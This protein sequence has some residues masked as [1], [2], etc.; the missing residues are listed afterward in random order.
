LTVLF[1]WA[2]AL[3][4]LFRVFKKNGQRPSSQ[5]GLAA[6]R[7][8][9]V[10]HQICRRGIRDPRVLEAMRK[11]ERHRFVSDAQELVAYGDHP[12][13]IGEGQTIS[14][15]YIVALMSEALGLEGSETVLEVGTGSGYQTAI[16][17]ELA[18]EVFSVEI[19]PGLAERA[20]SVLDAMGYR[21]VHIR[22][23]DGSRGWP[24]HAAY[25]GILVTAAPPGVPAALLEQLGDGG[26]LVIPVGVE[27]QELE[28]HTRQNEGF[29]VRRLAAV[30]FVPLLDGR[31]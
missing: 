4:G 6:E 9:M 21:N 14:Q 16:L 20:R 19:V 28:V 17:A 1:G 5:E 30:R 23:G 11:V 18:A 12:L 25:H 8:R 10:D 26:K 2:F 27:S 31:P 24:E 29:H 13:P 3:L 22:V 15:P 7:R